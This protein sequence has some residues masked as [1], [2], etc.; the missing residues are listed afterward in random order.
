APDPSD[1]W[2]APPG[3]AGA[4]SAPAPPPPSRTRP[5]RARRIGC[6]V[7]PVVAIA[8]AG[9]AVVSVLRSC[10]GSSS[11]G[12]TSV[13]FDPT[14]N[15]ITLGGSSST[16]ASDAR[17][18]DVLV[19]TQ[20]T[21]DDLV[22]RLARVRFTAD[23]SEQ[24]WESDPVDDDAY[25]AESAIVGD[26]LFAAY[27]DVLLALDPD[28]GEQRWTT[29]LHDKVTSGCSSCFAA[30]GDRLVVRTTDAYVTAYGERSGE[31]IWSERLRS[32]IGSMSVASGRLFVVDDPEASQDLTQVRQL[33]PATGRPV[34]VVTPS[35]A[36]DAQAPWTIE[37]SPGDRVYG[38]AGSDDVVMA[39]GF[40]DGCVVRW[41]PDGGIPRWAV[42]VPGISTLSR[43][44]V[45]VGDEDLVAGTSNDDILAVALD[46]GTARRLAP[47][48]DTSAVPLEIVGRTLV[49]ASETSRGTPRRGLV[50]WDLATGERRWAERVAGDPEP[51]SSDAEWATSDALFEGSP[52]LLLQ[53]TAEGADVVVFEGEQRT[54]SVSALD[55]ADGSMGP[56]VRRGLLARYESGTVSLTV[57][58]VGPE[59]IVVSVDNA[60]QALPSGGRGPVV[61]FPDGD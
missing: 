21:G 53:P 55:L 18:T 11:P 33:D 15:L 61:G 20:T 35:C 6:G 51:T 14:S 42:R 22:R 31:P 40:G 34:R 60:L 9:F 10:D 30:V 23:G 19:V 1:R 29:D 41:E 17:R 28:T 4:P 32:T 38:V 26:T 48:P 39:F 3:V 12:S 57:E 25:D 45:L 56:E 50:G 13:R 7:V 58:H 44:E 16:L 37:A 5:P 54:F 52:R 59:R 46:D 24:L 8:L 49:G 47:P 43:G 36:G 27:G 2:A